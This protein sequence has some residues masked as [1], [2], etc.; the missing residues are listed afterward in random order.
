MGEWEPAALTQCVRVCVCVPSGWAVDLTLIW[1]PWIQTWTE[2]CLLEEAMHRLISGTMTAVKVMQNHKQITCSIMKSV[3]SAGFDSSWD[4]S[5]GPEC[6]YTL[7][8]I[9]E[10]KSP[11]LTP[12]TDFVNPFWRNWDPVQVVMDC[13][14]VMQDEEDEADCSSDPHRPP[15]YYSLLTPSGGDAQIHTNAA[16]RTRLLNILN[17]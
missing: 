17:M 14:S 6:P 13:L 11:C 5:S 10:E 8:Q 9:C 2:V 16:S 1:F 7:I 3:K 15:H 12:G 4:Q